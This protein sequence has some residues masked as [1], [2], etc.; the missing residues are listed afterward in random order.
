[1]TDL[2]ARR[3][4]AVATMATVPVMVLC[5]SLGAPTSAQAAE[6]AA[7]NPL[8]AN[9]DHVQLIGD[10]A[11]SEVKGSGPTADYYGYYGNYY[12]NI[13]AVYGTYGLYYS[14]SIEKTYYYNAYQYANSAGNYYYYAYYYSPN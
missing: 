1:M 13:A 2:F 3:G 14:G 11:L 8:T 12:A 6:A 9:A 4:R 7:S 5:S 10:A